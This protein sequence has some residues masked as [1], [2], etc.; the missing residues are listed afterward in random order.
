MENSFKDLG[1]YLR[2]KFTPKEENVR[3]DVM[4]ER[5]MEVFY[6]EKVVPVFERLKLYLL[7][8]DFEKIDYVCYT[9]KA[10]FKVS[11]V[12]SQFRFRV[13]IDNAHRCVVIYYDVK[14][15]LGKKKKLVPVDVKDRVTV[16]FGDLALIDEEM[17][18]SVFIKWYMAKDGLIDY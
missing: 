2:V 13:D 17:L 12:L 1:D 14:Y 7:D 3:H 10:V 16:S 4:T 18:S 9:R 6:V 15:R 11:E 5:E 8:F